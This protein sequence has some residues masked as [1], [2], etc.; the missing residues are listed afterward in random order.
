MD[1]VPAV[2][3]DRDGVLNGPIMRDGR[4]YAPAT[5]E[6]LEIYP[7]AP[8]SL[9]ALKAARFLLPV[10]TNQPDV[11]RGTQTLANV[12]EINAHLATELPLDGFYVCYHARD[13]LCTCRKPLPGLLLRAAHERGIDL[14]HSF[15]IGDRWRD[16]DAGKA[17]GVRVAFIDR[18]YQERAPDHAPDIRV[19]SLRQASDW[20]L[21]YGRGPS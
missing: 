21:S 10:V 19:S 5:V 8:A 15:L 6:E 12:E 1:L 17:A 18:G 16:V 4:P 20:I 7:D 3:L 2:F 9:Q 11:A 13:G 14:E